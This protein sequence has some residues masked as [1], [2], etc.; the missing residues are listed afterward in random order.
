[1]LH[2]E[3]VVRCV[4]QHSNKEIVM[5]ANE[6]KKWHCVAASIV[7]GLS[8]LVLVQAGEPAHQVEPTK[9]ADVVP[10]QV[11]RLFAWP[12]QSILTGPKR[13]DAGAAEVVGAKKQCNRWLATVISPTWLPG[14]EIEFIFVRDE[15]DDRDVVRLAW[16]RKGYDIQVSQTAFV[17]AIKMTPVTNISLG[18]DKLQKIDNAQQLCLRIFKN[19][20]IRYSDD[21][22]GGGIRVPIHGLAE[23]IGTYSFESGLSLDLKDDGSVWG[24]PKNRYEANVQ[25]AA[26]P[27]ELKEERDPNNPNWE[28]TSSA[29]LYWFRNVNWWNDGNSIGFY[30]LKEAQNGTPR[31]YGSNVDKN[32]FRVPKGH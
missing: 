26:S 31:S 23:K 9:L 8:S 22:Q 14:E 28:N 20:G 3:R 2:C 12:T 17:F 1:M 30:F 5:K 19:S 10:L 11:Q 13:V 25:L 32:F 27:A 6:I 15:F 16:Q 18:A 7:L 4:D 24:R 21:E 29:Y